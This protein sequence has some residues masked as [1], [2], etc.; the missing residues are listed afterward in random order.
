MK[1]IAGLYFLLA[2]FC[3]GQV[4]VFKSFAWAPDA[5]ILLV[6]FVGIFR[7]EKEAVMFAFVAGL[8]RASLS[9]GTG[10]IDAVVFPLLAGTIGFLQGR[11][12]QR[13]NPIVQALTAGFATLTIIALPHHRLVPEHTLHQRSR[14]KT[15]ARNEDEFPHHQLSQEVRLK[16]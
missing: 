9:H 10:M 15:N 8:F 6:V 14:M 1:K 16:D 13:E 4:T 2:V 7:K 11:V 12:L 5:V 3:A